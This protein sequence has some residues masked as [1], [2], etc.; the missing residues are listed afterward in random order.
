MMCRHGYFVIQIKNQGKEFVNEMSGEFHLLTGVQQRITSA[1]HP[2]SNGLVERQ[3]RNVK[4]CLVKVLE[5]NQ[6]KWPSIIVGVLFA[7]R[8]SKLYSTKYFLFKL[9]QN[10]ETVLPNSFKTS[11]KK[12]KLQDCPSR[13]YK[14]YLNGVSFLSQLS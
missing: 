11:V 12:W 14:I 4:N 10:R 13:M 9:L 3:S 2:R 5:E 8:V 6:L 1:S 7:N